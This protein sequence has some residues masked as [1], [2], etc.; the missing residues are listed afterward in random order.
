MNVKTNKARGRCK[1]VSMW[2]S[3]LGAIISVTKPQKKR[4]D[5]ELKKIH[6]EDMKPENRKKFRDVAGFDHFKDI[7]AT[8]LG[9]DADEIDD[10]TVDENLT[11]DEAGFRDYLDQ[12]V[13]DSGGVLEKDFSFSRHRLAFQFDNNISDLTDELIEQEIEKRDFQIKLNH[14]KENLFRPRF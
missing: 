3:M 14:F 11:E 2:F 7:V 4:I 12:Y 6:T 8:R 9:V 13:T 5:S 10:A 1:Q